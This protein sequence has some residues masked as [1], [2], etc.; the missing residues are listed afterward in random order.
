MSLRAR[1]TDFSPSTASD[2]L[3]SAH[4]TAI[5]TH[6]ASRHCLPADDLSD[7]LQEVRIALLRLWPGQ[8]INASWVFHT[9]NHKAA[10]LKRQSQIGKLDVGLNS[11]FASGGPDPEWLHLLR[12]R[13]AILPA[14]L[15]ELYALRYEQGL[16]QREA[17]KRM[18]VRRKS[19]RLMEARCLH[20]LKNHLPY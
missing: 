15:R 19:I 9:A 17:A 7:L 1:Q 6:V 11:S 20:L 4:L 5:A 16:S 2:W 18:G 13:A 14:P 12:A 8:T 3:E 10:D